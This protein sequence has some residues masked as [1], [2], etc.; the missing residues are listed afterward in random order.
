MSLA[1]RTAAALV[2]LESTLL[3]FADAPASLL[4]ERALQRRIDTKYVVRDALLADLLG[5]LHGDYGALRVPNT[6]FSTYR[7]LYFDTE[8][9]RCFHDHRRGK[10]LRHKIRIR[11]YPDRELSF[12]EVKSKRNSEITDKHRLPLPY[13]QESVGASERAFVTTHVGAMAELR[14]VLRI[15]YRRITLIGLRSGE[16]VTIDT[17]LEFSALDGTRHAFGSLAVIEIKRA[18]ISRTTALVR[19]LSTHHVRELALSKY[20][21]AVTTLHPDQRCNRLRPALRAAERLRR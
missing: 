1:R 14:P 2:P 16:R 17:D 8:D 19:A 5:G 4:A 13:G 3:A 11:H 9:F 7:N 10:R 12:L 20:V 21:A 15:D 6:S 18:S